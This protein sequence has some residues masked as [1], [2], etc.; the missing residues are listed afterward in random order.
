MLSRLTYRIAAT[1]AWLAVASAPVGCSKSEAPAPAPA[2]EITMSFR[3]ATQAPRTRV[4]IVGTEQGD[5]AENWIDIDRARFLLFTQGGTLLQQLAPSLDERADDL[6]TYTVSATIREPYFDYAA[7]N[8]SVRFGIMVLANWPQ[9]AL[10]AVAGCTTVA[11]VEAAKASWTMADDWMPAPPLTGPDGGSGIPMYGLADFAVTTDDLRKSDENNPTPLAGQIDL[12]RALAKLEVIDAIESKNA[13]GYPRIQSVT[14]LAGGYV[15][16]ALLVPDAFANGKQVTAPTL[17][18]DPS[19]GGER[20]FGKG[21]WADGTVTRDSWTTYLP[22]MRFTKNNALR[23]VVENDPASV[24]D[25]DTPATFSY[26][27]AIPDAEGIWD[28]QFLRNHI[29]RLE[30]L[31]A[32]TDLEMKYTYT[33]CPWNERSTD[34]TFE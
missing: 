12:L 4:E 2:R 17:P 14:L 3:I 6:S 21:I 8:G 24:I 22:E 32:S 23:I 26:T 15:G 9:E 1:V 28:G 31:T 25:D 11:E 5:A 7:E 19:T 10:D 20:T 30:V 16:E 33:I 18:A 34:I 29:Y 13:G 27:L